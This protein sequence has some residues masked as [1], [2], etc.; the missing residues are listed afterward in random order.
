M[1]TPKTSEVS[2]ASPPTKPILFDPPQRQS[3][4]TLCVWY[5]YTILE[6]K[7]K[8]K[9]VCPIS[10]CI[11]HYTINFS[12]STLLR[13][14]SICVLL[15]GTGLLSVSVFIL[16]WFSPYTRLVF[17]LFPKRETLQ[18][19]TNCVLIIVL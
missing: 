12:T 6:I 4:T 14:I 19:I 15:F 17:F 18:A 7:D 5:H 10:M 11:K 1:S 13:K 3:K 9:Y 16:P 2:Q 8:I